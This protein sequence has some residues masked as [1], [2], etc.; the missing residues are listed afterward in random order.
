MG[1]GKIAQ[2]QSR[3]VPSM[4]GISSQKRGGSSSRNLAASK[5]PNFISEG[6]SSRNLAASK[7]S[8]FT[9][10]DSSSRNLAISKISDCISGYSSNYSLAFPDISNFVH[11]GSS[12]YSL[13]LPDISEFTIVLYNIQWS[14]KNYGT[15]QEKA[16]KSRIQ[17]PPEKI[18]TMQTVA[19]YN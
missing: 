5:M 9:S 6:S 10:G 3:P 2:L 19:N 4:R 16:T 18:A 8:D 11:G 14:S 7:M 12:N 17:W 1:W 13:A 15:S